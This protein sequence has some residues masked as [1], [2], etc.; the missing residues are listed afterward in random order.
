MGATV[1]EEFRLFF[2]TALYVGGAG[3]VYWLVSLDAPG[4]VL[5]VALTF[6]LLAFVGMAIFLSLIHI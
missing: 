2:R 3:L 5:L 4:T 1:A 6:A